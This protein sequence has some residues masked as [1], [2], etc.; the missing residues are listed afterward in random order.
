MTH[1]WRLVHAFVVSQQRLA[2]AL[3]ANEEL[4]VDEVV[5]THFIASQEPLEGD[6]IWCSVRQESDPDGRV[7]QNAHAAGC[8]PEEDRSRRRGISRACGSDPR[9]ARRRS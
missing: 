9:R 8:R 4:T 3:V 6:S 2:S 1:D 5:T 7:D